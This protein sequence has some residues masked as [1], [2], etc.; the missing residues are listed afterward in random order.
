MGLWL[1]RTVYVKAILTPSLQ[2]E[3]LREAD[4]TLKRV[5]IELNQVEFQGKKLLLD[6]ERQNPAQ[7]MA[8]KQRIEE[9]KTKRLEAKNRLLERRREIEKLTPGQEIL[10]DTIKGMVEVR[11]G[12]CLNKILTAEI[13]VKDG[14]VVA[15]RE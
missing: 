12:D 9:E 14:I 8:V 2:E 3:L 7:V 11:P 10:Q 6:A 4:E 1:E 15:V 5:E 13:V